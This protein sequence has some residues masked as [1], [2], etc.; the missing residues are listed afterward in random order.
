MDFQFNE[1]LEA[2][3]EQL[4]LDL[5]A[6]YDAK[7]MRASGKFAEELET[8]VSEYTAI[9]R[10]PKHTEQLEYGR[11]P[12]PIS[13]EGMENIKEWIIRKN[14]FNA[15]I[16][17]IGLSSLAF[18]IARKIRNFGWKREGFGGVDLVSEVVTPERIQKIIDKV[19]KV[20]VTKFVSELNLKTWQ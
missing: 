16:E 14:V 10:G 15:A 18:L 9:L 5:I 19:G 12:G 8:D 4:R 1:I 3:F 2:E 11:R 6:A 17:E 7:G 20:A 13:Y